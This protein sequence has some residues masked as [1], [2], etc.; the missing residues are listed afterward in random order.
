MALRKAIQSYSPAVSTKNY[1][2]KIN[3][4]EQTSYFPK[5]SYFKSLEIL[6]HKNYWWSVSE[7]RIPAYDFHFQKCS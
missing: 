5:T 1:N 4:W 3:E 2:F 7:V 6:D